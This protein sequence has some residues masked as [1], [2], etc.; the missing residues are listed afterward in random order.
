MTNDIVKEKN[1]KPLQAAE[2]QQV[3]NE[4]LLEKLIRVENLL[5]KI[6]EK[7]NKPLIG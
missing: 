6:D 4:M 1:E 3:T 2:K 5:D 7:L